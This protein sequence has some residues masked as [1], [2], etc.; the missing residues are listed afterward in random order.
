M[1]DAVDHEG[2]ASHMLCDTDC[3]KASLCMH[4]EWVRDSRA[5][6]ITPAVEQAKDLWVSGFTGVTLIKAEPELDL[7]LTRC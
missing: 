6:C 4:R 3:V 7:G 5:G 2:P 1:D